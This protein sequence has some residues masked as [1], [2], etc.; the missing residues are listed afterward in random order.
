MKLTLLILTVFTLIACTPVIIKEKYVPTEFPYV[1]ENIEIDASTSQ[2]ITDTYLTS[3]KYN[4]VCDFGE[5]EEFMQKVLR[6][7]FE[8]QSGMHNENEKLV[9]FFNSDKFISKTN[10]TPDQ[11]YGPNA[12]PN[13]DPIFYDL[14]YIM[15]VALD[16]MDTS[17]EL[18]KILN[19]HEGESQ[20]SY[21]NR[22]ASE[23]DKCE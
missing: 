9:K 1:E 5:Y 21:M 15:P 23:K 14:M 16:I 10:I 7:E 11:I 4:T 19:V 18:I 6:V 20:I 22:L 12:N 8:I 17:P 13:Y 3:Y 2:S